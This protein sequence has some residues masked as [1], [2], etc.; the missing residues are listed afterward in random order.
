MISGELECHAEQRGARSATPLL[1]PPRR[2]LP[3]ARRAQAGLVVRPYRSALI[4]TR[5]F[6]TL[7]QQPRRVAIGL[8]GPASIEPTPWRLYGATLLRWSMVE[9][10]QRPAPRIALG[11]RQCKPQ[12]RRAWRCMCGGA[13][14]DYQPPLR[15]VTPASPKRAE[16]GSA[17]HRFSPKSR[18]ADLFR[19]S[20]LRYRNRRFPAVWPSLCGGWSAILPTF[21]RHKRARCVLKT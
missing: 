5:K 20:L 6:F 12:W 21:V 10:R 7:P 8:G 1:R 19:P 16:A 2:R 4:Y 13:V 17:E 14:P 11:I 9:D 15:S 3:Q 18:P